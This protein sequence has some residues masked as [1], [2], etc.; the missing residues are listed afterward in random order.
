LLLRVIL[1]RSA[2]GQAGAALARAWRGDRMSVLQ[3]RGGAT[4]VIWIVA[5]SDYTSAAA[6][7][8]AYAGIL[9]RIAIGGA[10]VPYHIEH[11]G[12]AVLAIIGAGAAHSAE[13]APAVW[14]G[15]VIGAPGA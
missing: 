2:S 4:T 14:R 1:T 6:F 9:E 5:L 12:T 15:S 13:L 7:A 11:R 3:N 8:Q 10:P